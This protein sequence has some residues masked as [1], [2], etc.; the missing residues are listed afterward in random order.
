MR[1]SLLGFVLLAMLCTGCSYIPCF[2]G[3][4]HLETCSASQGEAPRTNAPSISAH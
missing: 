3:V 2:R 4:L 1:A